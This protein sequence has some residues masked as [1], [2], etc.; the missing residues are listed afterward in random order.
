MRY[1]KIVIIIIIII[2]FIYFMTLYSTDLPAYYVFEDG[3]ISGTIQDL[4]AYRDVIHDYV[5]FYQ[6]CSFSFEGALLAAGVPVRNIE[7][8][9]DTSAYRVSPLSHE[10][11]IFANVNSTF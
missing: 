10:G 3:K 11:D 8:N 4:N 5:T 2:L 7:Q 9:S 6:G 1:I